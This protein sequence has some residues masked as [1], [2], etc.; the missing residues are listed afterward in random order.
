MATSAI[1]PTTGILETA[2]RFVAHGLKQGLCSVCGEMM[3]V[4]AEHAPG[5]SE[6]FRH[7][8]HSLCPTVT[9][10]RIRYES[11]G[12]SE[13]DD[14]QAINLRNSVSEHMYEVCLTFQALAEGGRISEFRDALKKADEINIWRY[15]GMTINFVP[16]ILLT[17]VDMF[18]SKQS[19]FRD[20][21]FFFVLP[22]GIRTIDRLWNQTAGVKDVVIKI[23]K[24]FDVLAEHSIRPS[25]FPVIHPAWFERSLSSLSQRIEK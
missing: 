22:P 2:Y 4:V 21:D 8:R 23:S 20:T 5:T 10:N 1:N 13:Y 9:K 7:E 16:Y 3:D 17:F 6:H 11:L 15:R 24:N 14:E 12:S 25:L 19:V 18:E